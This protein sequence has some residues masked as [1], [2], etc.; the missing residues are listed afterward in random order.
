MST[1]IFPTIYKTQLSAIILP[2][3]QA[4]ISTVDVWE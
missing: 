2:V 1:A 4:Q 3:N